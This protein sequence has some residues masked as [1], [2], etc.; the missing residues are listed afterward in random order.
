MFLRTSCRKSYSRDTNANTVLCAVLMNLLC[1]VLTQRERRF[2]LTQ[3]WSFCEL[4]ELPGGS[5][6]TEEQLYEE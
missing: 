2:L 4:P 1:A 5:H 6:R 3:L